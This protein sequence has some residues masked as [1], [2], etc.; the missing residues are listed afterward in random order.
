MNVYGRYGCVVTVMVD[1]VVIVVVISGHRGCGC[2][3]GTGSGLCVGLSQS[4]E[5]KIVEASTTD[6]A[7]KKSLTR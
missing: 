2:Y 3:D 1:V 4:H 6:V 7:E 5:N